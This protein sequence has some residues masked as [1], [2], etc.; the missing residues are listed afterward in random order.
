MPSPP[1]SR[2]RPAPPGQPIIARPARK[3]VGAAVAVEAI[4]VGIPLQ[5]IRA[6]EGAVDVFDAGVDI[7]LGR[8]GARETAVKR[9]FHALGVAEIQ[10]IFA[11]AA[12]NAVPRR[13]GDETVVPVLAIDQPDHLAA[14]PI[15][16]VV[17]SAQ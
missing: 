5:P 13:T 7:A 9:D 15:V 10:N 2:S 14:P 17:L 16:E 11:Q 8:A 1:V 6:F 4:A 3:R 12:I